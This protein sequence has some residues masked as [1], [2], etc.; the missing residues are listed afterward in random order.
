MVITVR[1]LLLLPICGASFT[2]LM[3]VVALMLVM[4]S[5]VVVEQLAL[6]LEVHPLRTVLLRSQN[7]TQPVVHAIWS[8]TRACMRLP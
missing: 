7:D 8:D 5:T 3:R 1:V 6:L 4:V 2:G